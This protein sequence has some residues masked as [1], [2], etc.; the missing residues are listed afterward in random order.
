MRLRN[1]LFVVLLCILGPY[2]AYPAWEFD[3]IDYVSV[4]DGPATTL[5]DGDWAISFWIKLTT[6]SGWAED[7]TVVSV[8]VSS[9]SEGEF[10]IGIDQDAGLTT[11]LELYIADDFYGSEVELDSTGNEFAGNTNW[12]HVLLQRSGSNFVFYI[13][14]VASGSISIGGIDELNFNTPLVLGVYYAETGNSDA[15]PA[16]FAGL[17]KW[18]RSLSTAEIS[19]LAQGFAP[20]CYPGSQMLNFPMTGPYQEIKSG[21]AVTNSGTMVAAHPRMI[22]CGE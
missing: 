5:P 21:L 8:G 6:T 14:G 17:A 4:A 1:L 19:G 12:T 9:G 10:I 3:S 15:I 11:R 2:T 7:F 13:N 16:T 20:S 18:N 22:F